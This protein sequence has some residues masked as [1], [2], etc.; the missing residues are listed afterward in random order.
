MTI[1]EIAELKRIA[2]SVP[3]WSQHDFEI[4]D[5]SSWESAATYALEENEWDEFKY[6]LDRCD[7][8]E[9][10]SREESRRLGDDYADWCHDNRVSDMLAGRD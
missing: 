4:W 7:E 9:R 8:A 1:Q 10:E 6:M 5:K 3:T 2:E